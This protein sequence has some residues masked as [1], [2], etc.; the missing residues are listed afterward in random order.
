MVEGNAGDSETDII[1]ACAVD[2]DDNKDCDKDD[3]KVTIVDKLPKI[4]VVK[5]AAPTEVKEPGGNVKFTV[6]VHNESNAQDPL[7]LK[8]F[9]DDI[10]GDL[11]GQGDCSVPQTIQPGDSYSC[12]F[13]ALVEGKEGDSETDTVTGCGVDDEGNEVCDE[14]KATVTI[15]NGALPVIEVIKTVDPAER[16]I[17]GGDFTFTVEIKN[18]SDPNDPV[19]ITSL[20]D[21][22]H[23][24]LNGQGDCSVPQIIQP[25]D[26][27]TCTFTVTITSEEYL[28]ET[29]TVTGEGT[30]DEGNPV[31]DSDDAT[32]EIKLTPPPPCPLIQGALTVGYEDVPLSSL[33]DY[34]YNDWITDLTADLTYIDQVECNLINI[35]FEVDPE[36]RGAQSDHAFHLL[37][38]K[39]TFGSDG[40]VSL[41]I[42]GQL[43]AGYPK[44]F[45]AG[46]D[47]DYTIFPKTSNV[48]GDLVNTIEF[49]SGEPVDPNQKAQLV[50]VFNNPFQ[51]FLDPDSLA[52]PHGKNLFFDP[53]ID[54]LIQGGYSVHRGDVSLLAVPRIGWKW[55]EE[56]IPIYGA[57]SSVSPGLVFDNEWYLPGN[58]NNCVYNGVACTD[59]QP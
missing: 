50:I 43:Q 16:V 17:P 5:S 23:G 12:S 28:I 58:A 15:I 22:I 57:Y 6:V 24:D 46:Q 45:L 26:S 39:D 53:Y 13:T 1:T 2:E 49:K 9:V 4:K 37:F 35:A 33:I 29:D 44:A 42:N 32:I 3:A 18:L 20:V 56:Q 11:N 36:G 34:D 55:P 27:Y 40:T 31:K 47:N 19:T 25:G 52:D 41:Y 48:Y 59:W 51:F 21:N 54:V 10:H 30:D 14:D 38:P 7:T 8:Q